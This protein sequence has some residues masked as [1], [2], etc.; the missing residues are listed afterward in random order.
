MFILTSPNDK[1][2]CKFV[3]SSI[4]DVIEELKQYFNSHNQ[5]LIGLLCNKMYQC[6]TYLI[7]VKFQI[8]NR[9]ID[10]YLDAREVQEKPKG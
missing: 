7:T 1:L 4:E 9:Y 2:W 6:K 10:L 5:I 3:Y 8:G